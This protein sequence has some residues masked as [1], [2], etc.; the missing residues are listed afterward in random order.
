MSGRRATPAAF[1]AAALV[2]AALVWGVEIVAA[3]VMNARHAYD[4]HA[5]GDPPPA[6]AAAAVVI[7]DGRDPD[8]RLSWP[9]RRRLETA[10]TL[11]RCGRADALALTDPDD[12]AAPALMRAHLLAHGLFARTPRLAPLAP[13]GRGLGAALE[14]ALPVAESAGGL[15]AAARGDGLILVSDALQLTRAGLLSALAGRDR[16]GFASPRHRLWR[17]RPSEIALHARE[18]PA[19][20]AAAAKRFFPIAGAL[21]NRQSR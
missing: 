8:G 2:C 1:A 4:D 16:V 3:E 7:G 19:L 10:L 5:P 11:V 17:W 12:P 9:T 18:A 13:G 20:W 21:I 14:A 6:P 15:T